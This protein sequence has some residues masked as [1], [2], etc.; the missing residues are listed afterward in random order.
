MLDVRESLK[1]LLSAKGAVCKEYQ[2]RCTSNCDARHR[3][4]VEAEAAFGLIL[5]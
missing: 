2:L 4:K 5:L 3:M 1:R